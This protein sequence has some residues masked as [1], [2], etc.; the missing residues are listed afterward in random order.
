MTNDQDDNRGMP[1][2]PETSRDTALEETRAN[3]ASRRGNQAWMGRVAETMHRLST[4]P[5]LL[6][7][8]ERRGF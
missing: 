1:D 7:L 8:V 5:E 2:Q 4:D 3:E 6:R